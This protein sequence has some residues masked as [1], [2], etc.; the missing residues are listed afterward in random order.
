VAEA[1]NRE[2]YLDD[3]VKN[4]IYYSMRR[5]LDQGDS[6]MDYPE[7]VLRTLSLAGGMMAQIARVNP[8]ISDGE[9]A[10]MVNALQ[11]HWH[12]TTEQSAFV[13]EVAVSQTAHLMDRHR[14][15]R[16]FASVCTPEERVEFLDVLF[17]VAAADGMASYK[18]I[19]EIRQISRSLKLSNE[20]FI[21]AKL[22]LPRDRRAQ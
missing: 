1:P 16:Q 9:F 2:E 20:Q 8:E 22:K 11:T 7:D 10:A 15:A 4:K 5:G 14:L 13:A 3:F 21:E 19:E 12:L 18:E 17:A 6:Q